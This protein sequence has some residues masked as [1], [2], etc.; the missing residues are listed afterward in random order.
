MQTNT[1]TLV[2]VTETGN[3]EIHYS[4]A[5]VSKKHQTFK[6]FLP[7][8]MKL[9]QIFKLRIHIVIELHIINNF[10]VLGVEFNTNARPLDVTSPKCAQ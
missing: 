7:I 8:S 2:F 9:F 4:H 10:A 3:E 5:Q 1:P 6:Q